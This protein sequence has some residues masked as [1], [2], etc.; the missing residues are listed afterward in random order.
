MGFSWREAIRLFLIQ[1]EK[2][3]KSGEFRSTHEFY[4]ERCE[5]LKKT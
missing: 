5:T 3:V 1:V 2:S 4:L